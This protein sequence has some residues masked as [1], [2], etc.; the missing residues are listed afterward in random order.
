MGDQK[1]SA[2]AKAHRLIGEL[3]RVSAEKATRHKVT[4]SLGVSFGKARGP[5]R[6]RPGASK[7]RK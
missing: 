1:E 5:K 7:R 3:M 4:K 6:P 2:K